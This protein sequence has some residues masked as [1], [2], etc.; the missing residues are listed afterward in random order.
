MSKQNKTKLPADDDRS[1]FVQFSTATF[2]IKTALNPSVQATVA[3]MN[4]SNFAGELTETRAVLQQVDGM[5]IILE[6]PSI[7]FMRFPAEV[8]AEIIEWNLLEEIEEDMKFATIDYDGFSRERCNWPEELI[9]CDKASEE[10]LP[11]TMFPK[12]LPNLALTS[13]QMRGEVVVHMLKTTTRVT[14]KSNRK[15]PVK[16]APWFGQFLATF[17]DGFTSVH[18]LH[19]PQMHWY[20]FYRDVPAN[21]TNPDVDLMLQ[22]PNLSRVGMTFHVHNIITYDNDGEWPRPLSLDAFL[23]VWKLEPMLGCKSLTH[24]YISGI[25]HPFCR[26]NGNQLQVL[27]DFGKWLRESFAEKMQKVTVHLYPRFYPFRG[28]DN[29]EPL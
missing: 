28:W 14:I 12:W 16:I 8:R 18:D 27:R 3:A 20:N 17:P 7:D 4:D 1:Y 5:E 6:E 15:Q 10:E 23:D 11:N 24:V 21:A 26:V 25:V 13:H 2:Y 19:F 22:C 9:I 29:G